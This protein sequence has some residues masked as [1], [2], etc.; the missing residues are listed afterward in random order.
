MVS[1]C[2]VRGGVHQDCYTHKYM[3]AAHGSVVAP[4]YFVRFS[5]EQNM[6]EASYDY[7][8]NTNINVHLYLYLYM[9]QKA[10]GVARVSSAEL[11]RP[12]LTHDVYR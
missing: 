10:H 2:V 7:T 4:I 11:V 3:G 1:N 9:E 5:P 6:C 8:E 12:W